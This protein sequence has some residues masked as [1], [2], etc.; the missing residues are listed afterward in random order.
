C[1]ASPK[2]SRGN[3][4]RRSPPKPAAAP[5]GSAVEPGEELGR[6][7]GHAVAVALDALR[8]DEIVALPIDDARL[9]AGR[10]VLRPVVDPAL[11][12]LDA[13]LVL[14]ARLVDAADGLARRSEEPHHV[15]PGEVPGPED[16][17]RRCV[18]HG[19]TSKDTPAS[20]QP[21]CSM[22]AS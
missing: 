17:G 1:R 12:E 2:P 13:A 5:G 10:L 19:Q 18:A 11:V 21:L 6:R 15:V 14:L 7:F 8:G 9:R 3:C 20:G 16:L 22:C 4:A